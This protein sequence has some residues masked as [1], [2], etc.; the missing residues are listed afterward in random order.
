MGLRVKGAGRLLASKYLPIHLRFVRPLRLGFAGA[1]E[2]CVPGCTEQTMGNFL[3]PCGRLGGRPALTVAHACAHIRWALFVLLNMAHTRPDTDVLG[4]YYSIR[5]HTTCTCR[6]PVVD[7]PLKPNPPVA[8]VAAPPPVSTICCPVLMSNRGA[9][10]S[11]PPPVST[12]CCPVT[13]S[14]LGAKP[15]GGGRGA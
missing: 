7:A 6:R 13:V 11:A 9:N 4:Y 10:C 14:N 5:A 12:I 2:S 3:H 1:M 8:P 15:W